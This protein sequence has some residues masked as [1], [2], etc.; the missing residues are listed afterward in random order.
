MAQPLRVVILKSPAST[1]SMVTWM[2]SLGLHAEQYGPVLAEHDVSP[3][4]RHTAGG[5]PCR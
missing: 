3:R 4:G 1:R 5:V 2:L